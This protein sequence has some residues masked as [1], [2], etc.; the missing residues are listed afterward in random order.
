M[1]KERKGIRTRTI[2][3]TMAS[4]RYATAEIMAMMP[5]PMAENMEPCH[6][7]DHKTIR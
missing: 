4:R 2:A 5:E 6:C 3:L 7:H 1:H